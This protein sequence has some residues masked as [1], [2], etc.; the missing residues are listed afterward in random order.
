[1]STLVCPIDFGNAFHF[2]SIVWSLEQLALSLSFE[3]ITDKHIQMMTK[4]NERFLKALKNRD[5][6]SALDADHDF[7]SVYIQ[8]S[9]NKELE[10][11]LSRIKHK[12]KRLDLY[13]FEK[14]KNA[15]LSYEEHQQII[16]A[17]KRKDL[18]SALNAVVHNWKA[19]LSRI[20]S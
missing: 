9:Q 14:I 11:I 16:D 18:P 15:H 10:Q 12:L 17:L 1:C 5:R 6:L 20:N 4:A 2:Y 7:H 13:Y 3:A 8:L 19:S